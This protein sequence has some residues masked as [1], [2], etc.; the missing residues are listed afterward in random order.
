[1]SSNPGPK[2]CMWISHL[3]AL[4]LD[5]FLKKRQEADGGYL[6]SYFSYEDLR[7]PCHVK[8]KYF[9][10]KSGSKFVTDIWS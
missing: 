3:F 7:I 8:G 9:R 2:Y 1:M 4:K 10:F 5:S 6:K